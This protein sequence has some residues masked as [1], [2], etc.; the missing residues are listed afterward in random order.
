[1]PELRGRGRGDVVYEV[2]VEVPTRLTG[3]QRE[4]LEEL[5]EVSRN[6]PGS[7]TSKFVERMKKLFGT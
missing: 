3:R 4:L 2:S 6:E 1:M 5:R 7:K